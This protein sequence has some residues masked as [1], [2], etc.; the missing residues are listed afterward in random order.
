MTISRL[1]VRRFVLLS[2]VAAIG[3][4][5]TYEVEQLDTHTYSIEC[6]GGYNDWSG[7][8][9]A[10]KKVCDVAGYD[11]VSRLSNEGSSGLGVKDWSTSGSLV[12]R[13]M[14]VRCNTTQT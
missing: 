8:L 7:C 2:A 6:P 5:A 9:K 14:V 4:C 11:I 12:S 3:A 1:C 13:T 10:A